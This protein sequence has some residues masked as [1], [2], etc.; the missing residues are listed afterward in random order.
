MGPFTPPRRRSVAP[1]VTRLRG[2][3]EGTQRRGAPRRSL[4]DFGEAE[5]FLP[6]YL[7]FTVY[8]G[9]KSRGAALATGRSASSV[10]LT[11]EPSSAGAKSVTQ[12]VD[13]FGRELYA[14]V[15]RVRA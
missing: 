11:I 14:P 5:G 12:G 9:K 8:A 13:A 10:V 4:L 3:T 6:G 1:F 15:K 7:I 2:A